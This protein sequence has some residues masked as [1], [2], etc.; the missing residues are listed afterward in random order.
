VSAQSFSAER[1]KFNDMVDTV[2]FKS[3]I[4][5]TS[6]IYHWQGHD[7]L[8]GFSSNGK[9]SRL[10]NWSKVVWEVN[11]QNEAI[12]SLGSKKMYLFFNEKGTAFKTVDWGGQRATGKLIFQDDD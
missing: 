5:G 3:K 1:D 6:W 9:I 4:T 10:K 2:A 11:Q 8:F 12:L 7:Y